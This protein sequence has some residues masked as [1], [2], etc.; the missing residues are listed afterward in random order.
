MADRPASALMLRA[1]DREELE[2]L[3]RASRGRAGL[4]QRARIVVLAAD[5]VS[6]TAVADR[7]GVSA[8][9][10]LG[11][12]DR[13]QATGIDGLADIDRSAVLAATLAPPPKKYGAGTG[14]PGCWPG[15]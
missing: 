9:T 1:G 5:G 4:A 6:N 11:W 2:R 13:Y 3:T 7:V 15:T 12:R 14:A 10:L 8:E